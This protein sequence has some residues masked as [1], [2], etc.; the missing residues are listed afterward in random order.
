MAWIVDQNKIQEGHSGGR[1][2]WQYVIKHMGAV[3]PDSRL[4]TATLLKPYGNKKARNNGR[5]AEAAILYS[6]GGELL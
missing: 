3:L 4:Y 6:T 5:V 2:C 1:S